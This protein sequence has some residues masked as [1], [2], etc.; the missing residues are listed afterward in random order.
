[1]SLFAT[2]TEDGSYS[3]TQAGYT[4]LA[5]IMVGLLILACF[6]TKADEKLGARPHRLVFSAM[7]IALAFVASNIKLFHLPTGG[8]ITFF[9]MFF[10]CLVGYWYGTA[11]GI[12]TAVAYG[13]LQLIVDPYILSVP[14][15]LFDYIFAFAALGLSGVF[16]NSKNGM[17]KGFLLGCAGRFLFSFLSGLIF[18]G[19]YAPEG[20]SPAVYS[21]TYNGSYIG[22]EALIT[23]IL[24]S[25]PSVNKA[26]IKVRTMAR[27]AR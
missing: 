11:A 25:I 26:L 20:V 5:L 23:V 4:G 16:S 3:L 24:I 15:M 8:S 1:M 19:M 2:L 10:V 13:L 21:A 9:S 6:V 12:M 27:Q 17:T 18:F 7:A 22:V 14:Q